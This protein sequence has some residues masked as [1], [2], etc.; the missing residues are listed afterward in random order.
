MIVSNHMIVTFTVIR[1]LF[2]IVE[3]DISF[4]RFGQTKEHLSYFEI[5]IHLKFKN[6]GGD[7][8]NTRQIICRQHISYMF[9]ST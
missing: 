6:G 3:F 9:G 5:L 2:R 8:L 7:I 1:W 4:Y